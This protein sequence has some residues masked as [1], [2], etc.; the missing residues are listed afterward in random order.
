MDNLSYRSNVFPEC[1][2]THEKLT[3]IC[4]NALV[5]RHHLRNMVFLVVV[6]ARFGG[7]LFVT[8]STS[9]THFGGTNI[10]RAFLAS[11]WKSY[12]CCPYWR[13]QRVKIAVVYRHS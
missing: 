2:L 6:T 3:A 9:E 1:I 11:Y 4:F 13:S 12:A 5:F 8:E 7:E 10:S